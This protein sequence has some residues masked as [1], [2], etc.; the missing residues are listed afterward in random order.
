M[1]L[2]IPTAVTKEWVR[3]HCT[4]VRRENRLL[5][6]ES[7]EVHRTDKHSGIMMDA[8]EGATSELGWRLDWYMEKPAEKRP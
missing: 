2:K 6:R 3:E 7:C 8:I 4:C 5:C 1:T